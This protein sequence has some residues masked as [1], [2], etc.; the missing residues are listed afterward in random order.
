MARHFMIF[1]EFGVG[2]V[3]ASLTLFIFMVDVQTFFIQK[4]INWQAFMSS[5]PMFY[6]QNESQENGKYENFKYQRIQKMPIFEK[7]Y[8][9]DH[10][11]QIPQGE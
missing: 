4:V 6:L 11:Y 7:T 1:R 9:G 8:S 3:R 5:T 10:V 2:T